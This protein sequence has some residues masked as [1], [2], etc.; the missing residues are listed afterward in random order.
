MEWQ[1]RAYVAERNYRIALLTDGLK[2]DE[3]VRGLAERARDHPGI[4]LAAILTIG[5]SGAPSGAFTPFARLLAGP[6]LATERRLLRQSP[7]ISL[8]LDNSV[9]VLPI[10]QQPGNEELNSIR[11]LALDAIVDCRA[12]PVPERIIGAAREGVIAVRVGNGGL[13]GFR[14]VLEGMPV[15][16]FTIERLGESTSELLFRGSVTTQ[17]FY[18]QGRVAL[19]DRAAPYLFDAIERLAL[20]EAHGEVAPSG[21]D[22]D[23]AGA[24]DIL[25]YGGRTLGRV[26]QKA[27]RHAVGR[28]W[29]WGVA[30]CFAPWQSADLS[31]GRILPKLRETF[32]ADPFVVEAAGKRYIFVEEFPYSTRKGVISVFEVDETGAKRL[33]V[34]LEEP[35]H[36]SFPFVFAKDGRFYMVPEGQGGGELVLYECEDFPLKWV[37][38]KALL[39]KVCADTV[40]FENGSLSWMLT[41]IKGQGRAE[42][43]AELHAFFAD[44]PLGEWQP[45]RAN[46]IVMDASKGRNGG[47]LSDDQGHIFRVAQRAGFRTYGDGFA[48]FRIDE[49]TPDTYEESLVREVRPDFF[50]GLSGT[51]HM[52]SK[53]GLTVY[54]FSR[55]ERP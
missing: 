7:K 12:E 30:Y 15:T 29:N 41:T 14:E 48:I 10:S 37:R 27:W 13:P 36:L 2:V 32:V 52:H 47:L 33:G 5:R 16:G 31:S 25:N 24:A 42:N 55:D 22:V 19:F 39:P 45:H 54:D 35:F 4:E 18:S 49:L 53:A 1:S 6:L 38:K 43:S 26:A 3:W 17:L 28:E 40:I 9:R 23:P 11:A 50:P 34:A 44:D 46:P 20:G 21:R 51:H 8:Q